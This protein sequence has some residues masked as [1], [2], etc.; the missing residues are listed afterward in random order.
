[1]TPRFG[2]SRTET[3]G[4]RV[5]DR[6]RPAALESIAAD[7]FVISHEIAVKPETFGLENF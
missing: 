7:D 5:S 6:R 3:M 2:A 4:M 1:M